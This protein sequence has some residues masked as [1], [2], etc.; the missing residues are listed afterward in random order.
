M[1][2]AFTGKTGSGKT[3]NMVKEAFKRWKK[4]ENIYTNTYLTFIPK[5]LYDC[6]IS[7][8]N[9][10]DLFTAYERAKFSLQRAVTKF[11]RRS[12]E[13]L[14]RG[15]VTMFEEI[16]ELLEVRDGVIFV[17]EGQ[18]LFDA[19]NWEGLP[20]EFSNKLRQH[21]KHRLDLFVTTQNLGTID[22]NYR[23][24]VQK[25]VHCRRL[26]Q[27]GKSPR[28]LFGLFIMEI[29]DIDELYNQ[30]DDLKVS[31]LKSHFFIIH[32]RSKVLYD[33]M[34]DV[35]FKRFKILCV[36]TLE[37]KDKILKPKTKYIILPR[38]MSLS[39]ARTQLL[40]QRFFCDQSKSSRS[41]RT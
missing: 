1:I 38:K 12:I 6:E 40:L 26:F 30:V 39:S 16:S 4:G 21:R 8:V 14:R 32:W 7:I 41:S 28:L 36:S 9:R 22:I 33:T 35:G 5:D 29:K 18:A 27:I 24:L 13:P 19:R 31:V 10:P 2:Y 11:G 25:W 17:D 23:R 15:R 34:Y 37:Q 3:Y 20:D